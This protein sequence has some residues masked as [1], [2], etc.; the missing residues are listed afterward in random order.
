MRQRPY[1]GS[2]PGNCPAK[3]RRLYE[4][5]YMIQD[6]IKLNQVECL[7]TP[8][9]NIAVTSMIVVPV[10]PNNWRETKT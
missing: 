4:R 10:R 5:V 3:K 8:L 7:L 9:K 1:G 2:G 6:N